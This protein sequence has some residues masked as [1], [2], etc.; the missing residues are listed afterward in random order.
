[1][2]S[3]R[4]LRNATFAAALLYFGGNMQLV[5]GQE[6]VFE[7]ASA[8]AHTPEPMEDAKNYYVKKEYRMHPHMRNAVDRR[9][10]QEWED[11]SF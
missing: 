9:K 6:Q 1:M 3:G 2:Q 5:E 7:E 8:T 11:F 4:N 10:L